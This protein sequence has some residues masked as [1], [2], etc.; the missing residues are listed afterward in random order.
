MLKNYN[1]EIS[2]YTR[3]HDR[4]FW[5][6][7]C[8]NG[9]PYAT[10]PL[11]CPVCMSSVTLVYCDQTVGRIKM[12]RG[13]EVGLDPGHT[14]LDGDP[15][16]PKRGIALKFSAHVRC[17]QMY[18]WI[19]MPGDFVL[20]GDPA[21]PQNGT[22]RPIFGPYLLWTNGRMNQDGTWYGVRPRPRQ[23]CVR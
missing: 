5:A 17:G 15:A 4:R 18:G 23:H 6:T 21:S 8:N 16:S 3:R 9:S 20:D 1:T 22:Q 10:G 7:V 14:V 11:S 13:K 19:K 2:A 12:K